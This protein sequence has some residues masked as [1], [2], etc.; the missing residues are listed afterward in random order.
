MKNCQLKLAKCRVW[1][2]V[3][4]SLFAMQAKGQQTFTLEECI[5]YAF[6]H[7]PLLNA[8]GRD[9]A[10]ARIGTQRVKGLYLPRANFASA[11]QYYISN[12][13]LLVEG[14]TA[15]A[16]PTLAEGDPMAVNIG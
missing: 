3:G 2:I 13:K 5:Q 10:I 7:N 11:M 16:P 8:A 1:L 4:I 14:G 15:L 9:T 6:Q 12:R